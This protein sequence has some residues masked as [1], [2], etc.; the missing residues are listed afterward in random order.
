MS[1]VVRLTKKQ[2]TSIKKQEEEEHL[3]A[4]MQL[5]KIN[6]AT[7]NQQVVF[8]NFYNRHMFLHGMAGTGKTFIALYLALKEILNPSSQYKKIIIV[9]SLVQTR[10]MGFLPGTEKE[11]SAVYEAPYEDICNELFEKHGCYKLLKDQGM[12]V[13]SSTSF[14][15]GLTFN[16]SIIIADEIQ[17]YNFEEA[18]SVFT[19][20]GENSKLIACGDARQNDLY[21]SSNDVSGIDRVMKV[22]RYM[23]QFCFV[24]FGPDDIL[25]SAFVK[26]WILSCIEVL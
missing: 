3:K 14:I 7:D 20:V 4:T 19:R 18:S 11:K 15:R 23:K 10:N 1:T 25:R 22:A 5:K 24:E 8:K 26:S 21:R 9:R 17:N 12:I 2:K 6:P 13:F 16:D